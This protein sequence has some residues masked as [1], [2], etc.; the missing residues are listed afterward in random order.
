M[1]ATGSKLADRRIPK[2][3]DWLSPEQLRKLTPQDL[4]ARAHALKPLLA[5][6]AREAEKLRRPVDAV[7]QKLR[8][9][10]LFYHFVPKR[11]GGL[12]FDA[13]AFVDAM[14]PLSEGCASTGW[15][16]AFCVEHNWLVALF[17][18][19]TQDEVFGGAFP[20]TIAPGVTQPMGKLTPIDGGYL[21]TARW[22]WG[23][24]VMHADWIL[25]AAAVPGEGPPKPMQ[26]LFPAEQCTVIDTWDVDGMIAT[27]SN[28]V[29]VEDL[30][31]P[32]HYAIAMADMR[33]AKAPGSLLHANPIYRMP[34]TPFLV[35]TAAI[36][37]VGAA[38]AAVESFKDLLS[39]RI[40]FGS[41]QTHHEK[42]AQQMRLG[43]AELQA[44]TAEMLIRDLARECMRLAESG[45]TAPIPERAKLRA[46]GAY[47]IALCREAIA[48][49]CE[50]AGSSAHFMDHPLQRCA[51]DINV[52]A[53]HVVFD[54]DGAAE[55]QGRTL[56]GLPPN[57]PLV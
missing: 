6:N 25:G 49:L 13:E 50:S 32:D 36:A 55:L 44:R 12:E 16:T 9:S 48:G 45:G 31:I 2:G 27:G 15:V 3:G 39:K 20:Y 8:E 52:I 22:K 14:L 7:W 51:R 1:T 43:R 56:L 54:M 53:S 41:T 40:V 29:I 33:E 57:T 17:P 4:V 5:E 28:D 23:T 35:L 18:E 47:A 38:R 10:G 26:I 34:M 30:F 42:P 37:G 46:Q 24:G 11:Y 19:R 21:V